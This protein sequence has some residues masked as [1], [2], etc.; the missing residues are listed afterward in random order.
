MS[1]DKARIQRAK[2]E[3]KEDLLWLLGLFILW[4]IF[5]GVGYY[6][7]IWIFGFFGFF[8][9]FLCLPIT[10][11]MFNDYHWH[12]AGKFPPERDPNAPIY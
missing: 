2:Q 10:I 8:G 3:L 12:A 11:S 4:L 6:T 7:K 9:M 1:G 5:I